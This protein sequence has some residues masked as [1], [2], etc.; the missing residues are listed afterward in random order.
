MA[1]ESVNG[2]ALWELSIYDYDCGHT[3]FAVN[4]SFEQYEICRIFG[5][6]EIYSGGW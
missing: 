6:L 4:Y 5:H 2:I 3:Q 1:A